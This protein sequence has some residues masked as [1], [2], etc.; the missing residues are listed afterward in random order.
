MNTQYFPHFCRANFPET[1]NESNELLIEMGNHFKEYLED[2]FKDNMD[3]LEPIWN[4]DPMKVIMQ[5]GHPF[6]TNGY[7]PALLIHFSQFVE[8]IKKEAENQSE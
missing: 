7:H 6:K 2:K 3:K 1:Q 5:M 4:I 8:K